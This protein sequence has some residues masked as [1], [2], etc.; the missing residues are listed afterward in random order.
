M[1]ETHEVFNQVPPLVDYN[2]FACDAA[3]HDALAREGGSARAGA[4]DALGTQLGG[5]GILAL[6]E[7]AN[8]HPPVLA[9]H[10]TCGRRVDRVDFDP[11]WHRLSALLYASGVHSAAWLDPQPGAHVAR[12]AA[13]YLHGQVEAGS[14]CPVTMTFAALPLLRRE[15]ALWHTLAKRFAARDYDARDL[16]LAAKRTLSVGMGLTEKQGG[17]DLRATTTRA[18]A[19]GAGGRG[20]EYALVGHKWFYSAP[21]ADAHLVLARSADD[22]L[23]CFFVPRWRPDGTRNAIRIE[24]LKDKLG[25]R[26]NASGEVEFGDAFGVLVGEPGRGLPALLAMAA[27]TRLDCVLGSAAL[28]RRALTEA[29]HHARHRRAFGRP[30]LE[31]ALM[32]NVLADL[33]LESEAALALALHLAAA[34]DAGGDE[35]AAGT[36]GGSTDGDGDAAALARARRRILTPA[37][38]FWVCKRAIAFT[39]ECMEICGGNGYIED[40]PMPRLLRE[41]PVNSIWEGAGNVMCLDVLR[42]LDREPE[43]ATRLVDD[44]ADGCAGEPRLVRALH[45]LLPALHT[46]A[47]HQWQARALTAGLVLLAQAALLRRDA[48][49]TVA[50]SFIASRFAD[51]AGGTGDPVFGLLADPAAA[52]ILL[53]RAWQAG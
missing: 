53:A 46:S 44:L 16:P 42:A 38:K 41:A 34:V 51:A 13:F 3:L 45:A 25:N 1:R 7:Q 48:P 12:A 11:A 10:D 5:T 6:G 29:L 23:S 20:A 21:A 36:A 47:A 2:L 30:L 40:G 37:A 27:H 18:R 49:A 52:P 39:A 15:P 43:A 32:R 50:D 14:L 8:R 35:A 26:A 4:L 33:A 9:T 31:H 24:R 19:I 17:S 22:A 28:M